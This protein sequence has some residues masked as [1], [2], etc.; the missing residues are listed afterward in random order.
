MSALRLLDPPAARALIVGAMVGVGVFLAPGRMARALPSGPAVLALFALAALG[1]LGGALAYARWAARL[2][3][4]GGDALFHAAAFGPRAGLLVGLLLSLGAFC[5]SAAALAAALGTW[6]LP[7]ALGRAPGFSDLAWPAAAPPL[8]ALIGLGVVLGLS[9]VQ[10]A[11]VGPFLRLLRPLS[12]LP[13]VI[14]GLLSLLTLG[15]LGL[16]LLPAPAP[17]PPPPAQA[18]ALLSAW[19]GA[20][21][22]YAGWTAAAYVAG[23]LDDPG[24][25]LR[26]ASVQGVLIVAG[27]YLLIV[28]ALIAGL[29]LGG[30]ADA[31]EAGSALAAQ[32]GGPLAARLMAALIGVGVLGTIHV[33]LYGGAHLLS[34]WATRA[35]A[36]ALGA[37][38]GHPPRAALGL[39]ALVIGGLLLS[40][41]ADALL[42]IVALVMV[43]IGVTTVG[44]LLWVEGR[45]PALGPR[46]AARLRAGLGWT[47]PLVLLHLLL[48]LLSLGAELARAAGDPAHRGPALT[49]LL[50][51]GLWAAAARRGAPAGP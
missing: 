22:A 39:Q 9:A 50:F 24:P 44:G 15:G 46:P 34:A 2:R 3:Q 25:G 1:A 38:P 10:A 7:A 42:D 19:L 40:G 20:H 51:F 29:G 36:A 28:G 30:L 48:G 5:G 23:Q 16:G 8:P 31:G 37:P 45:D 13:V 27:L 32:L 26:R 18:G 49:L 17:P 14:L 4:S 6:Q 35:G 11:G 21:F 43:L 12:A 41:G 47:L 33:T